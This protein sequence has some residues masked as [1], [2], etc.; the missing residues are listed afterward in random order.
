MST[1]NFVEISENTKLGRESALLGN[2]DT[3]QIYYQAVLQSIQK[4]L[5]TTNDPSRKQKWTQVCGVIIY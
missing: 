1:V 4:L 2:Y 3:S 5:A